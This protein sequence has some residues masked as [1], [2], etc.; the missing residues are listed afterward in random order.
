MG[1]ESLDGVLPFLDISLKNN[2]LGKY[3]MKVFRKGA[4][5]NL[6]IHPGSSV[7]PTTIFGVF[8]GFLTRA[9]RICTPCQLQQEVKFLVDMFVE[10]GYDRKKFQ[11]IADSFVPN[12]SQNLVERDEEESSP[13]VKLPW[14]PKVGPNLRK[15]FKKHGVRVVFTSG[16]SL[17]DICCANTQSASK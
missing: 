1:G 10:N 4:I 3:E 9:N 5:T 15:V 14:I 12:S 6:Q 2:R 16:P 13:I 11:D 7:D 8:K 17:K